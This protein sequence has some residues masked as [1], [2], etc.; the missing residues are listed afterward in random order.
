MEVLNLTTVLACVASLLP[1]VQ[2]DIWPLE[3]C[4][5]PVKDNEGQNIFHISEDFTP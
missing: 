2:N 5:R 1:H 4:L 3:A